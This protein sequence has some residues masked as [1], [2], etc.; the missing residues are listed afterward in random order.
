MKELIDRLEAKERRAL[1]L[2]CIFLFA[3]VVF[4][5]AFAIH[6]K[7]AY[8]RSVESIPLRQKEYEKSLEQNKT[9]KAE[10]LRWDE[11]R[12]DI[13]KI[14]KAYFYK[15]ENVANDVRL[16]LRKIFQ[17]SKVRC[18]S[19]L[20]FEYREGKKEATN[21]VGVRFTLAGT[22]FALKRFIFEVE[23][24]PKFLMIEKIDFGDV[25]SQGGEIELVIVLAGYYES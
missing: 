17:A 2:V 21:R 14:E 13:P 5:A 20:R 18:V 12:R 11:A 24:L 6:Q 7:K 8:F 3:A 15:E 10:W 22:Y 9:L 23:R 19:D 4:Y 25:A 16:D 1:A